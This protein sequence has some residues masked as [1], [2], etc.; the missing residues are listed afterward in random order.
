VVRYNRRNRSLPLLRQWI[1]TTT[2]TKPASILS[3]GRRHNV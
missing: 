2:I 3:G 1:S